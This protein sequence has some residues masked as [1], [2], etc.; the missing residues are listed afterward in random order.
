MLP[1]KF[2]DQYKGSDTPRSHETP[3]GLHHCIACYAQRSLNHLIVAKRDSPFGEMM[4]CH[5]ANRERGTCTYT[6]IDNIQ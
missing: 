6:Y 3:I 4:K 5:S 2:S 1:F